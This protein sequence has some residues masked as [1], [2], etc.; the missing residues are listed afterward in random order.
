MRIVTDLIAADGDSRILWA[1]AFLPL[2]GHTVKEFARLENWPPNMINP[3]VYWI[4]D[5]MIFS[6]KHDLWFLFGLLGAN[7]YED[8]AKRHAPG[9]G[10]AQAAK[11]WL[12]SRECDWVM[13]RIGE[14]GLTHRQNQTLLPTARTRVIDG[15][16]ARTRRHT[17]FGWDVFLA[18]QD[19]LQPA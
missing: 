18:M 11:P 8:L 12:A 1:V 10:F 15:V 13:S 4:N 16:E 17:P 7:I 14:R 5:A 9:F 19:Q 3:W 6:W 2:V